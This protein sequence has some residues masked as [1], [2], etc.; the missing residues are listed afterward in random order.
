ME[1]IFAGTA[2]ADITP[3]WPVMLA[4]FGQR[5]LPASTVRDPIFAKALYL[6]RGQ[7]RLLVITTDLLSIPG[8]LGEAVVTGIAAQTGLLPAQICICASHT[9]SAPVPA[10]AKDGATGIARYASFVAGRLIE[11][12]IAAV[13]AIQPCRLRSGVGAADIFFNRR[14]AGRPNRVDRRIPVLVVEHVAEFTPIAVL[15]GAGCHPTSLGWDN[16]R[17]SAD[18]TGHAQT[19]VERAFGCANA[20]FFNTAQGNIIPITSPRFD[21]LDPRGYCGGSDETTDTLGVTLADAVMRAVHAATDSAAWT[22]SAARQELRLLP[23]L[24]DLDR[25][26]A[27]ARME[28]SKAIVAEY[29]G[30]DFAHAF[31]ARQLWSHASRVVIERD[32]AE[33]EMRRLMIACCDYRALVNRLGSP[34]KPEAFD[35]PVQVLR[36][37]P[38]ELLALPGEVLVESGEEWSLLA[39][40]PAAFVIA[41]ANSHF[42]YLPGAMHFAE[43]NAENRY[44]TASAGLEPAAMNHAFAAAGKMLAV[45]RCEQPKGPLISK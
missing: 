6:A 7:D 24:A 29:L 16:M 30:A 31:P 25:A 13:A 40:T 34:D 42:R 12:G 15:F 44:E 43:P 21:A 38:F 4:G 22:L 14:T 20:L 27:E 33:P 45:L 36:I 26:A 18:F 32:M 39:G 5:T 23:T 11:A 17:I 28:C 19:L 8:S 37:G 41:C 9:H 1:Q 10:F 3:D 2:R 35:V